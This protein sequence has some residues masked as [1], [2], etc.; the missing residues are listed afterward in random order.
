[1]VFGFGLFMIVPM[2]RLLNRA[3]YLTVASALADGV[4]QLAPMAED[5][6]RAREALIAMLARETHSL[7]AEILVGAIVR[8]EPTAEDR[9]RA[10]EAV[11]GGLARE[12][13]GSA[14]EE[15]AGGLV[16]HCWIGRWGYR[17]CN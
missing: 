8:L 7:Q 10:R 6:C 13:D 15:L 16:I 4:V 17:R 14:A 9:R 3:M 12:T 1:M 11:L 2:F 5:K